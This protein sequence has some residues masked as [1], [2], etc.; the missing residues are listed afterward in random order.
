M[1]LRKLTALA[2]AGR[3]LM[4]RGGDQQAA[5]MAWRITAQDARRAE[6]YL[7][8]AIDG[9]ELDGSELA[10]QIR[11]L[12][13]DDI[14]LRVN[15]PGG[16]VFDGIAVHAALSEH[17]AKVTAHVDGL[18]ASAASFIV[19]AADERTGVKAARLMIHDARGLALGDAATMREM[20]DLLDDV[21]D[22]IAEMYADRAGGSTQMWRQ[23]MTATTWYSARQAADAGLLDS[24]TEPPRQTNRVDAR[25]QMI[26]ARARTILRG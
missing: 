22:T 25:T 9:W 21:S 10:Q 4:A 17:P 24:V 20:A 11:A 23:A 1:D 12:D 3:A 8:G 5:G 6:V 18:A 26:R 14:D 19:Q 7:Y 2:D 16:L 15:S 13:V